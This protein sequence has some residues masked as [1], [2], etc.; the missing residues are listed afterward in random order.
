MP[1]TVWR[2]LARNLVPTVFTSVTTAVGR[3][4]KA[5]DEERV[6]IGKRLGLVVNFMQSFVIQNGIIDF[7]LVKFTLYLC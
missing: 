4:I 7:A 2:P 6:A 1:A 5:V 3:L